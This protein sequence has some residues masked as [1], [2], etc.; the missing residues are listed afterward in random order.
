L[1]IHTDKFCQGEHEETI[2]LSS[3]PIVYPNP[4]EGGDLTIFLGN[5]NLDNVELS[6]FS[7][8]GKSVVFNKTIATTNNSIRFNVDRLPQGIYIVNVKAGAKLLTYK[9]IRK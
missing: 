4:I 2:V 3:E 6:M 7:V 1:T 5:L 8:S 9:I